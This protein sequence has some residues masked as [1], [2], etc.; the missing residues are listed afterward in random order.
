MISLTL[1]TGRITR[2]LHSTA[3]MDPHRIV[4]PEHEMI[5]IEEILWSQHF[6]RQNDDIHSV[7]S[8]D[9]FT[10]GGESAAP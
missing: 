3:A 10:S 6:D 9:C 7:T 4:A 5:T 2:W 1:N 8:G